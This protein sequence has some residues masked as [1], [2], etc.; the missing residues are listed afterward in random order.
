MYARAR[1]RLL[2]IAATL[3]LT[4]AAP[5]AAHPPI[6]GYEQ[7]NLVSNQPGVADNTDPNLVNA[8]GLSAGPT[9]PWWVS[10]NGADVS[11]LYN[12]VGT[13]LPLVVSVPGAPTGTVF[14]GTAGAFPVSGK[15]ATFLFDTESGTILGWNGGTAATVEVPAHGGAVYK[16]L[17]IATAPAGPRIYATDFHNGVV[18]V[19]DAAWQPVPHPGFVDPYLPRHFAPFGI[20]AIGDRIFVTYAQ[21]QPG[22]DDEAH[23]QGLGVVDA[24]DLS[25]H[26]VARVAQFGRLNAPWGL[27][28]APPTFGRF[29]G[30]L[31]VGNFGD[32]RITAYRERFPR[33]FVPVG[34]LRATGARPL[35]ID[36]LWALEFGHGAPNNGPADTLFFTAGP[37]DE[38]N[39]LFGTIRA[40][41][42]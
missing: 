9:S 38:E 26:L 11:T 25:G 17:A 7:H 8:W 18:D 19:F 1:S 24:F 23:G 2:L 39:G 16:G 12:A 34:Q 5:A 36:G 37:G 28:W 13:P 4:A 6:G 30:D 29:A 42:R 14:N 21:Q 41:T 10:D 27:A 3:F 35:S 31:L 32:G 40:H 15:A 22:S 33:L 20:Q